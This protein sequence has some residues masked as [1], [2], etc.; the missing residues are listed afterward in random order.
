MRL[1]WARYALDDRDTIFSYIE[2]KNPGAA[3]TLTRRSSARYVV[4][5]IFRK[6]AALAGLP[7]LESL[8]SLELPTLQPTW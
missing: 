3:V 1:V 7:E 8:L 2:R 6:A 5:L 4:C